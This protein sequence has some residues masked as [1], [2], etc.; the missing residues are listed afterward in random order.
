MLKHDCKNV[1]E[2]FKFESFKGFR[3]SLEKSEGALEQ[4]RCKDVSVQGV[5][6]PL[7]P[8]L[9]LSPEVKKFQH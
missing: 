9:K 6:C 3:T 5:L 2:S 8:F 1:Q 7:L 4:G